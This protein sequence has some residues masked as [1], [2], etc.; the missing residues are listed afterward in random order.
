MIVS[1]T[2]DGLPWCMSALQ[3][4]TNF[5]KRGMREEAERAFLGIYL[6]RGL[7]TLAGRGYSIVAEPS[8][9]PVKGRQ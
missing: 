8:G 1:G 7:P 2:F 3:R 6:I 5:G 4:I 9:D